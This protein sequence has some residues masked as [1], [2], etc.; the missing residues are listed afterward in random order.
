MRLG[1]FTHKVL[2]VTVST[3]WVLA[4]FSGEER[5]R[6]RYQEG[7][8]SSHRIWRFLQEKQ[9]RLLLLCGRRG[10]RGLTVLLPL[11]STVEGGTVG[12]IVLIGYAFLVERTRH[13]V[14]GVFQGKLGSGAKQGSWAG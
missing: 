9:P 4:L 11:S 6:D 13:S 8:T 2:S 5:K 7:L 1:V 12:S 14:Q 3:R 10:W